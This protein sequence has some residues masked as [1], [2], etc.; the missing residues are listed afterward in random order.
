MNSIKVQK[1]ILNI[2]R[3]NQNLINI[4]L[5]NTKPSENKSKTHSHGLDLRN[6]R[7]KERKKTEYD[8]KAEEVNYPAAFLLAGIPIFTFCL[9]VWQIRRREWKLSLIKMLDERTQSAPI[10][11]PIKLQEITNPEYEYRPFKVRGHFDH[12]REIIIKMRHDLTGTYSAVGGLVVTPFVLS[13]RNLTILVNRGFV[14][15]TKYKVETRK[16][17]QIE[18]EIEITGLLRRTD[19]GNIFSPKNRPEIDEWYLRDV[20]L[21]ARCLNTAPIFLDANLE[22]TIRNKRAEPAGPLG[23]QTNINLRNDHVSY[24]TTWFALSALTSYMWFKNF[25]RHIFKRKV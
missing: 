4:R 10:D 2:R 3:F 20:D 13:D 23:G 21:M 22:S 24:I 17:A 11:L 6:L 5:N 16:E 9:G 19:K 18:D 7:P 25:G 14:P 8:S 15:H 1:L 12:S